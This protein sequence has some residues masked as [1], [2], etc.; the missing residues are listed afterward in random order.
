MNAFAAISEFGSPGERDASAVASFVVDLDNRR[1]VA[2][3]AAAARI[4]GLDAADGGLGLP[5]DL[6]AGTPALATLV[7]LFG[8][9]DGCNHPVQTTFWTRRGVRTWSCLVRRQPGAPGERLVHVI[10]VEP[11]PVSGCGLAPAGSRAADTTPGCATVA[12]PRVVAKLAH[13]LRTPLSA[14]LTMAD[15]LAEQRFGPLPDPRYADYARTISDT[16][17]HAIGVVAAMLASDRPGEARGEPTFVELDLEAL[18]TE[19]ARSIAALATR[20]GVA[21]ACALSGSLPRVIADRV[22]NLRSIQA[23]VMRTGERYRRWAGS[24]LRRTVWQVLPLAAGAP[25]VARVA[26]VTAMA[27][28]APLVDDGGF[29]DP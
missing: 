28:L 22:D 9:R 12:S 26:L 1:L 5:L 24:Y 20:S 29:T 25:S 4:W 14:I 15:V 7:S 19:C 6:D 21:I 18:A 8:S 11:L 17:R 23:L 13:E 3:D 2:A 27:D 10:V 16:A